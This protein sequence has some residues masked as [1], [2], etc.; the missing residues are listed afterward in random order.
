[1]FLSKTMSILFFDE[2]SMCTKIAF[3][4][5]LKVVDCA[6]MVLMSLFLVGSNDFEKSACFNACWC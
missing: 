2:S 6:R 1:M 5:F 3:S 4:F